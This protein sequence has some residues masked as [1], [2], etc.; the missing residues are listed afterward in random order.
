MVPEDWEPDELTYRDVVEAMRSYMEFAWGK[1]IGHRGISASRSVAK[2][3]AWLWLLADEELHKF[4]EDSRNYPQY[5]APILAKIS[6]K[7]TFWIPNRNDVWN[8]IE[9]R[10]CQADCQMGCGK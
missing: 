7:Y 6:R 10:P 5:G 1:V 3:S 8:M 2:M 9:G 4:A